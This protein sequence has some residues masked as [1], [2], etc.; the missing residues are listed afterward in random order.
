MSK[1]SFNTEYKS[2]VAMVCTSFG[3][4]LIFSVVLL[5][6]H[7]NVFPK[8]NTDTDEYVDGLYYM[9]YDVSGLD[10]SVESEAIKLG[11]EL[12][13]NTPKYLGPNNGDPEKI[14]SGNELSCN[15]CHLLAGTK[16][17]SM[18][19]IGIIQRFPQFR[20][21]ENKIGTIEDRINGCF[22]RSMNGRVLPEDSKEMKA[23]VGY[24]T[25][26]SRYAPKDGNV[27]GQGYVDLE[28][29]NRTVNLEHGKKVFETICIVCHGP[30]G[31]GQKYPDGLVYQYPP[32][33]GEDS[34]NDG[35]GMNR[36]ITAAEFIKGNMPFG[37]TYENVVLTDEEAYDVAGYINSMNR[38][39]MA[40]REKD[41][42]DLLKK[43][44]STP[45]GPYADTFSMEQHKYGPFQPIMEYYKKEHNINKTK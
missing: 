23:M 7:F 26:L 28:I 34:F 43:P 2:V 15:N 6:A 13:L 8:S 33:W 22:E 12:F 45:Y 44:I 25:F 30:D 20:G 35:A 5:M 18:P 16:P 11:Y 1:K 27:K 40:N 3:C 24:L 21:R 37:T 36:V 9:N 41:F 4:L 14:Y 42:P 10:N 31:Q 17:Y 39:N 38:P 29:P 32:L 19:M